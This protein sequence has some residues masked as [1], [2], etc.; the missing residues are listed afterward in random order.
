MKSIS[1]NK[2]RY[3]SESLHGLSF[4][5]ELCAN[6]GA[7]GNLPVSVCCHHV[8][9]ACTPIWCTIHRLGGGMQQ[10]LIDLLL[11]EAVVADIW[12]GRYTIIYLC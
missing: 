11:I 3:N 5:N 4:T 1:I 8:S 10:W 9:H 7:G 2:S 6:F 12:V